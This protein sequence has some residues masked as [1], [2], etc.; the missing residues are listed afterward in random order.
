M[1]DPSFLTEKQAAKRLNL[2]ATTLARWRWAGKG[3]AF[4]KFE[5]AIRYSVAELEAYVEAAR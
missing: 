5:G 1:T 2:A 3:P 4:R